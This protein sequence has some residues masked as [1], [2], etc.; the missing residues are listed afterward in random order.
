MLWNSYK[1]C[2]R[3]N[4]SDVKYKLNEYKREH[5]DLAPD[6]RR[7]AREKVKIL[8]DI[9]KSFPFEK[10]NSEF[11]RSV[12]N[13]CNLSVRIVEKFM[14]DMNNLIDRKYSSIYN[15]LTKSLEKLITEHTKTELTLISLNLNEEVERAG[16][17]NRIKSKFY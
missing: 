15:K 9:I 14:G 2:R 10:F 8:I 5:I 13:T 17:K 16:I 11:S 1:A 3:G 12:Q 4:L 6:G 7:Q